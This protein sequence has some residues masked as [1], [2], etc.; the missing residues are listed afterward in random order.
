M[1]DNYLTFKKGIN[2]EPSVTI[3]TTPS[4]VGLIMGW[5]FRAVTLRLTQVKQDNRYSF[6]IST[7]AD[8][9]LQVTRAASKNHSASLKNSDN[10]TAIFFSRQ[11]LWIICKVALYV[12]MSVKV[13][14]SLCTTYMLLADDSVV[15]YTCRRGFMMHL[16]LKGCKKVAL[17]QIFIWRKF[18]ACL[19]INIINNG[20]LGVALLSQHTQLF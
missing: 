12:H 15:V 9:F 10:D 5:N 7:L 14:H 20:T 3:Y 18:W 13:T 19:L 1:H 17:P 11:L 6:V 8:S 4:S 2:V 16:S